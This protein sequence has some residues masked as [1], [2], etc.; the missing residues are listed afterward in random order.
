MIRVQRSYVF[1]V[2]STYTGDFLN[3]IYS[4]EC[5]QTTDVRY[6][7]STENQIIQFSDENILRIQ[8]ISNQNYIMYMDI[9]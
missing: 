6:S 1:F 7:G 4:N 9:L 3:V 2:C 8:V 5:K